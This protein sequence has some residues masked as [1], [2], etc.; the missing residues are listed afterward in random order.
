MYSS[1]FSVA[2]LSSG[3]L[4]IALRPG[5]EVMYAQVLA[6]SLCPTSFSLSTS[7]KTSGTRGS[8]AR[9]DKVVPGGLVYMVGSSANECASKM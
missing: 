4:R 3:V 2:F 8:R 1:S 6:I 5:V 7:H 9:A